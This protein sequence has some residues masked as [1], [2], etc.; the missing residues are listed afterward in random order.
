MEFIVIGGAGFMLG[1]WITRRAFVRHL[2]GEVFKA[3]VRKQLQAAFDAGMMLAADITTLSGHE[4][5][6][7]TIRRSSQE[8]SSEFTDAG[9]RR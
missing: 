6:A 8:I 5:L 2:D 7:G 1:H 3:E 9:A 4:E